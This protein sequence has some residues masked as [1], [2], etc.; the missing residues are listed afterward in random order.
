MTGPAR[1]VLRGLGLA[2]A[3]TAAETALLVGLA[4]AFEVR[5]VAVNAALLLLATTTL[6]AVWA[7]R[8]RLRDRS[9]SGS[10][11]AA[12]VPLVA[13]ALFVAPRLVLR[14]GRARALHA[15]RRALAA[16]LVDRGWARWVAQ[17]DH[18]DALP[19]RAG[20]GIG[21]P[22][23]A[24]GLAGG[25]AAGSL[26]VPAAGLALAAA[27]AA[28]VFARTRRA[29]RE[30]LAFSARID[31]IEVEPDRVACPPP[32]A[33]REAALARVAREVAARAEQLA[34]ET[35]ED[36]S[37]RAQIADARELR[38]RFMA[39]MSHE[40]RS[41]STPSSASRSSSRRGSRAPSRAS[42]ARA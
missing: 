41:P 27:L 29:E 28:F 1:L 15:G 26:V 13:C 7:A 17:A 2:I 25:A 34:I 37:A 39:S 31:A 22:V 8:Q 42:S 14:A 16:P 36:T 40:L 38:T 9:S 24:V 4:A 3:S 33:L 23:L 18:L 32:P 20:L 30:T 5:L 11:A 21:A 6:G 12:L 10:L 35:R 19:E